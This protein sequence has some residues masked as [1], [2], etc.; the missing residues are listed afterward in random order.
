MRHH[1]MEIREDH[2]YWAIRTEKYSGFPHK[3]SK[4]IR[5]QHGC[6]KWCK[7][8]FTPTDN[9]E[10]DHIIPRSKGGS[11]RYNNLQALHKHCHIQKSRFDKTVSE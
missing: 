2:V 3:I 8:S 1:I 10:V 7:E 5:I 9:I 6:S 11:D 4:L